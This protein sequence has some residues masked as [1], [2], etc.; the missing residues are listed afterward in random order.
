MSAPAPAVEAL[1]ATPMDD[2]GFTGLLCPVA[3]YQA[4]TGD[5]TTDPTLL[6]TTLATAQND[7]SKACKRTLAYGHYYELLYV[8]RDGYCFPSAVPFSEFIQPESAFPQ[9]AAVWVGFF[10]PLPE[11]PIWSGVLPPQTYVEYWG[12]F[13]DQTIP[14]RLQQLIAKVAW[15]YLN[16][17]ALPGMPPG[18]TTAGSGGVTASGDIS[19]LAVRDRDIKR[20]IEAFSLPRWRRWQA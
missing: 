7:V 4:F 9:G 8:Y 2:L 15:R 18:A 19:T 11:M 5:T 13:T 14:G 1:P 6:S 17:V 20:D 16:P 3:Q 10:L 12:G